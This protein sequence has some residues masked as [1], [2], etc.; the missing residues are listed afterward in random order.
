MKTR[1]FNLFILCF[2]WVSCEAAVQLG[3]DVFFSDGVAASLKGKKVGLITNHTGVDRDLTLTYELFLQNQSGVHLAAIF[4]PEHG[5]F[6]QELAD[7]TCKDHTLRYK[8]PVLSLYGATKRPTDKMLQGIDVLIYD[9][10]DVGSR[11][12]TY[13]TT[14]YYVMEEAA[15]RGIEVIVL[16]RPNPLSGAVV[17]G[18]LLEEGYRSFTGY[19]DVP[20]CHGMTIGELAQFFY[21][22]KHGGGM[23]ASK[24]VAVSSA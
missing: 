21:Q 18:P 12:Y 13:A 20:Y 22:E 10:Q 2:I 9:I 8:V 24:R 17:D 14:L 16:D 5:L 6:G 1:L 7:N 4:S 11:P 23:D 19:I 3:V 15:K